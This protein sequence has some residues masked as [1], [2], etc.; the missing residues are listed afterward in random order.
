MREAVAFAFQSL[1][2]DAGLHR[3]LR[4]VPQQRLG[5]VGE[6]SLLQNLVSSWLQFV[7]PCLPLRGVTSVPTLQEPSLPVIL[8]LAPALR[9]S[10]VLSHRSVGCSTRQ[11]FGAVIR[12]VARPPTS[13]QT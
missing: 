3:K 10:V 11:I 2:A 13:K 1:L 12:I 7:E 9:Q 6:H 4:S 5:N 8:H